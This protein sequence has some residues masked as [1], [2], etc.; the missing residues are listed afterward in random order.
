MNTSVNVFEWI[1]KELSTI[2]TNTKFIVIY[3]ANMLCIYF[4]PALKSFWIVS[5]LIFFDIVAALLSEYKESQSFADF[6]SN[7][8]KS[9]L[10]KNSVYKLILYGIL[11][12]VSFILEKS[13]FETTGIM[14]SFLSLVATIEFKSIIQKIDK[15][16]GTS[17]IDYIV[18][19]LPKLKK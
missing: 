14:K 4:T 2:F 1:N 16:L 7:R 18:S 6:F 19:F 13:V 11:L 9:S 17:I 10:L 8:F 5:A 12:I 3:I 15:T